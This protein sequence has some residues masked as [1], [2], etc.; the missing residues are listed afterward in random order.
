MAGLRVL[1]LIFWPDNSP[2]TLPP[3]DVDT[4]PVDREALTGAAARALLE[5]IETEGMG[6]DNTLLWSVK[7]EVM[8]ATSIINGSFEFV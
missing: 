7:L 2:V 4:K 8:V 3:E 6:G 1:G 5:L